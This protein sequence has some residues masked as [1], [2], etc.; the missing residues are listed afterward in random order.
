MT[1]KITFTKK[2]LEGLPLPDGQ[3]RAEYY[4]DQVHNLMVRVSSS[5]ILTFYVR[6]KV[7]GIS[8]RILIGRFPDLSIDQAR[9]K[10]GDIL[11]AIANKTVDFSSGVKDIEPRVYTVME[12]FDLYME[13]YAKDRCTRYNDMRKDFHRYIND[14][15]NRNHAS[16]TSIDVQNRLNHVRNKNGPSA[17]NHL[18][19]LMRAAMNWN[20]KNGTITS[21]PWAGV[22]QYKVQARERFLR[23]DEMEAFF[24]ALN[25][26]DESIRDYVL[27][28]LYTGARRSN[29]LSMRWDQVDLDLAVWRIPL[30]KNKE[31]QFI[32]LTSSAVELLKRRSDSRKGPWVFPGRSNEAHL[33]EPKRPWY[34]LLNDAKIEDLRIH[35]LRRTLAS[36]MAMDN[37]SL[38]II[39]KALG[40][41]S[42][43]S[44]QIYSR[45][46]NDPVRK[47]ME[48]A[49]EQ[50]RMLGKFETS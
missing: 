4:D 40:H 37:Q 36:Y 30:T 26:Q 8:R 43:A 7:D 22:K 3:G 35:D 18:L 39:G 24:V 27:I 42:V 47:A 16:I 44:T 2:K 48:S 5:G 10:A 23:P 9:K 20:L 11:H 21:N 32:P 41:K 13:S 14:W 31:S 12:L 17:A 45:L 46:M 29:V 15:R 19:I 38:Q 6:R 49:Q 25:K 33:V 34:K 28:S 1:R 50:I